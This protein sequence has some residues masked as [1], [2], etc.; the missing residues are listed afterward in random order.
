ME[1]TYGNRLHKQEEIVLTKLAGVINRTAQRGGK[2]VI[3]AFA[4]GRTQQLV[5][6]LH[7]LANQKAIPDLPI[8]VDSPLAVNATEAY[9]RH[10]SASTK[11]HERT[12]RMAP[13]RSVSAAFVIFGKRASRKRSMTCTDR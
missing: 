4:V 6:L 5:L 12:W 10:P 8:F 1:S 7:E 13:I 11:R 2:I 3:P 9:R